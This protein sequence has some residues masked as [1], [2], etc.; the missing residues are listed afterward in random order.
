[1]LDGPVLCKHLMVLVACSVVFRAWIALTIGG[2]GAILPLVL[3]AFGVGV[4]VLLLFCE[5]VSA[6]DLHIRRTNLV[7]LPLVALLGFGTCIIV[8]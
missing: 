1:M 2:Y 5:V 4:H 3:M 6:D 8:L 7:A